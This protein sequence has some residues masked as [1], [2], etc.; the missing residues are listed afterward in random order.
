[1]TVLPIPSIP[2]IVQRY[3]KSTPPA[4]LQVLQRPVRV[5][6]PAGQDG[7]GLPPDKIIPYSGIY[8]EKGRLPAVRGPGTTFMARV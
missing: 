7:S 2:P 1:M 8:N 3:T 5:L 6:P 4:G